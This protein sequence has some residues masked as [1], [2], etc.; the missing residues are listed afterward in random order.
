MSS[1]VS[2][3]NYKLPYDSIFGGVSSLSKDQMRKVNGYSNM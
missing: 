1:A 3:F 2:T